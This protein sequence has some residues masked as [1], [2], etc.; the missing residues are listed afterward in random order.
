MNDKDRCEVTDP[1]LFTVFTPTYNRRHTL[2][3]VFDSLQRQTFRSFE[4]LVVD[5][6]ST[7]ATAELIQEYQRRA[8]FPI[9]Y[10]Y[11]KNA[12]K[13]AAW[14][15]AVGLAKGDLFLVLDSDDSCV[16]EALHVFQETWK[17][18]GASGDIAAVVALCRDESGK[19]LGSRFPLTLS[20]H[21]TMTLRHRLRGEKWECW[22]TLVL[23]RFSFPEGVPGLLPESYLINRIA[24][25]YKFYYIDRAL[26]IYYQD[27]V[28]LTRQKDPRKHSWGQIRVH[29]DF[30]S[31]Y[32]ARFFENPLYYFLTVTK[33]LR[34]C[35]HLRLRWN[36]IF[37]P[38]PPLGR[39]LGILTFPVSLTIVA[40]ERLRQ[41]SL[42]GY[43]AH[44]S[45]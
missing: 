4:W 10:H 32:S 30:L 7:D 42:S 29:Q 26:R 35:F 18:I 23:K 40:V 33:Y 31:L 13:H 20:D 25:H 16:P 38:L 41:S 11:Q 6:G 44:L 15:R 8:D 5:D 27:T 28:S 1:I 19:V 36:K 45:T 2:D 9:S 34:H 24:K 22:R 12:G 39:V 37:C 14:N 17:A 21:I 43:S 3:R